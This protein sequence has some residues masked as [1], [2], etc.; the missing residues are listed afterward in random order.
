M[1]SRFNSAQLVGDVLP[2]KIAIFGFHG[3]ALTDLVGPL[4][5]LKKARSYDSYHRLQACYEVTVVGLTG[6]VFASL[7]GLRFRAD[8]TLEE[9][10]S[11][12]DLVIIPGGNPFQENSERL[13]SWL[14]R[15]R[16]NIRRFA[17]VS[18]GIYPLAETGLLDGRS[19]TSHWRLLRQVAARY[20]KLAVNSAA[21]FLKDGAFYTCGGGSAAIEMTLFLIEEDYGS[22]VALEVAREFVM[23]LRPSG[24][25]RTIVAR[26]KSEQEASER[27]SDLPPWIL[28][29]L[30][31]DLSVEVLAAHVSLC[32]RHF[33][34]IFKSVFD[35]TPAEFVERLRLG[36]ARRRLQGPKAT[37]DSVATSV[38]FKSADAFSRAFRRAFGVTPSG[39]RSRG[40]PSNFRH[41]PGPGGLPNFLLLFH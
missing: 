24:S 1:S 15:H 35:A 20:P 30:H 31:D 13:T 4:E 36:E 17:T 27:L 16:N 33:S 29:H 22:R 28:A 40:L 5:A 39:F 6:R 21:S 12:W 7:S 41:K 10:E 3:V 38:G 19:V 18:G 9:I 26:P 25:N 32:P 37:I 34:R 14:V 11:A 8:R 23:R 2:K